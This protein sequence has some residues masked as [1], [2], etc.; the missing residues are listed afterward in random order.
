M[1]VTDEL[2]IARDHLNMCSAMLRGSRIAGGS[3]ESWYG[4][5]Y[6]AALSWVWDAQ[7]R[8][9]KAQILSPRELRALQDEYVLEGLQ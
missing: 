4:T 7:Q 9:I 1:H 8:H 2:W 5:L 3:Q 6:I